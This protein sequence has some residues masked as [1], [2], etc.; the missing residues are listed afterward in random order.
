MVSLSIQ[1]RIQY[2]PVPRTPAYVPAQ[3]HL[4]VVQVRLLLLFQQLRPGH[5]EAWDAVAAL[6]GGV[7][8]ERLLEG[9]EAIFGGE[10]FDGS[11]GGVVRLGSRHQARHRCLPIYPHG[12]GPALALGAA[13]FRAGQACVLT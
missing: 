9:V 13:L 4:H 5:D 3:R 10:A 2:L 1:N 12:A 6:H 8:Y 11:D 7:V